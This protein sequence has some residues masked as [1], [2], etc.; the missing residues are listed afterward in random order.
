MAKKNDHDTLVDAFKKIGVQYEE[1]DER[2]MK[3][4][5]QVP[6][7]TRFISVLVAH[8]HFDAKGKFLGTECNGDG[9]FIKA[10]K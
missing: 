3:T 4:E 6:G 8:Y 1:C 9:Q 5:L 2:V 7:A 10:L